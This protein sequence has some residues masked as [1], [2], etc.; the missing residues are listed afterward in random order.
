MATLSIFIIG[1]S[2][3]AQD[4]EFSQFYSAPT[5]VNPATL[6]SEQSITF[7][8]N[9][10]RQDTQLEDPNDII[11]AYAILPIFLNGPLENQLGGVGISAYSDRSG[12]NG[13]IQ[14][15]AAFVSGAYNIPLKFDNSE[16]VTFGIQV[17]YTQNRVNLMD[18][19]VRSGV[20]FT[21]FEIDGFDESIL[22]TIPS[23]E[24]ELQTAY[25]VINAGVMYYF[26]PKKS[27]VLL[28]GSA[29]SGISVYNINRPDQSVLQD[30][31]DKRP[32]NIRYHGG[33]EFFLLPKLKWT[34]T[35]VA[36]YQ[37]KDFQFNA[38]NYFSYN[39]ARNRGLDT[40]VSEVIVGVWYRLKDAAIASVGFN[41]ATW[42]L[43]FSYD[44]HIGFL[45]S[46]KQNLGPAFE[47]S[48]AYRIIRNKALKTFSTPLI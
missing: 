32:L 2:G 6:G 20:Q 13:S 40:H 9:V 18:L 12:P 24:E 31:S 25:P 11:H 48:V 36:G 16:V 10:R 38:G 47:F 45:G 1:Y 29:F 42:T 8:A 22:S 21:P 28:T 3:H 23:T 5:L 37:N 15:T 41:R 34:P 30:G 44:F 46:D 43:G 39:V 17:G 35:I 33:M 26:N 14:E 19:G 27:Y 4:L 7:G